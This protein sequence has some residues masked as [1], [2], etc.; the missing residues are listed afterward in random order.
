M[1]TLLMTLLAIVLTVPLAA[2]EI[3]AL[4]GAA[5]QG[6][7][8]DMAT[9]FQQQSGH[10]VKVEF[11]TTPNIVKRLA[12]GG[13]ADILIATSA[14]VEQAVADG[15]AVASTRTALGRIGI[16]VAVSRGATRPDVSTVDAL[17]AAILKADAVLTS[18]GASGAYVTKMLGDL[19]LMEQ[20]KGKVV[21]VPSG[22]A[23]M[24]RLGT[25][26][27]EIGFTMVSEVMYGEAHGGGVLAGALPRQ[28][29]NFTGYDAAVMT[30]STQQDVARQFV[31]LL[32]SPAARK[33][34][35]ASGWEVP[36]VR[37]Q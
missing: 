18:Q 27:N 32:T 25:S 14:A 9:T 33:L 8:L 10:T 30:A 36:G 15:R 37:A 5:I 29:Q 17:T 16:G 20:I 24:D 21:V 19:G 4:A 6:P 13:G 1:P 34:L 31:R 23:L 3:T 12:G 28:I 11:D 26:R 7:L 22:V 35:T 2:V